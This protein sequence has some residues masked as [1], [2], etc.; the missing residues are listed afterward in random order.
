MFG[1]CNLDPI[2]LHGESF[3]HVN[4]LHGV[5]RVLLV[6][7]DL[8]RAVAALLLSSPQHLGQVQVHLLHL[9]DVQLVGQVGVRRLCGE[10]WIIS[11]NVALD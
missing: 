6:H 8:H 4:P 7:V 10:V 9:V 2:F 1:N 11:L 3:L 5:L